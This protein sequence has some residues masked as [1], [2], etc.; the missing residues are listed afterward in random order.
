V[1]LLGE[2]IDEF[3]FVFY[4]LLG[5]EGCELDGVGLDVLEVFVI[6]G[7]QGGICGLWRIVGIRVEF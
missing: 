5:G 2:A 6:G 4:L 1:G 3:D 7:K